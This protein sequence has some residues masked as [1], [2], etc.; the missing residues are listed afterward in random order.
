MPGIM[1]AF[2]VFSVF[3]VAAFAVEDFCFQDA[4]TAC[5]PTAAKYVEKLNCTAKYGAI[6]GLETGIQKFTNHHIIRSF[7]Y[8]LLSTNFA[9]YERNRKG[10]EKLFRD[11]SDNKWHEGIELIKYITSRGGEH[12]FNVISSEV[13]GE[14]IEPVSFDLRELT[15]IAKALDT[16]KKFANEAHALHREATRNNRQFHDPEISDYIEHEFAHKEK[17][18]IRKLAGYSSDLT[19]LLSGPDHSLALFMFDEYLQKQ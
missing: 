11:L 6:D 15:A 19:K 17:D 2:I 16:E 3:Y 4:V 12:N 13:K 18:L 8:L 14:E 10:F 7:E 5:N 1:K 9:T